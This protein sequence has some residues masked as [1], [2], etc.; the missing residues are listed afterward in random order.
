M[1]KLQ[2]EDR[3]TAMPFTFTA[4]RMVP[5]FGRQ[6]TTSTLEISQ[7]QLTPARS[8]RFYQC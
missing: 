2:L 8:I 4:V 5:L 6:P 1:V 7:R 3:G